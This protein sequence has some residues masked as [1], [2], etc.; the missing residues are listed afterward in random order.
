MQTT[1]RV[2]VPVLANGGKRMTVIGTEILLKLSASETGG[3]AYVFEAV[4][5]PGMGVPL[6]VHQHEDEIVQI[7]EGELEIQ[8]GENIYKALPGS[9]TYFPRLVP[10]G[11][12]NNGTQPARVLFTVTPGANFEK[13]FDELSSLPANQPPDMNKVAEIFARYDLNIVGH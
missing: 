6:H 2:P 3:Q 10:H 7:L 4:T 13:F 8:L 11:F 12:K 1:T 5:S 9:I